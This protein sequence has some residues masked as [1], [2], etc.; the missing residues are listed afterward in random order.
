MKLKWKVVSRLTFI[1]TCFT[2]ACCAESAQAPKDLDRSEEGLKIW[3]EILELPEHSQIDQ[4]MD[5]LSNIPIDPPTE[6]GK[7]YNPSFPKD[8]PFNPADWKTN[9]PS[10]SVAN[11]DATAGGT[12][13]LA[14][15]Q[16]PPTLRTEGPNSRLAFLSDLHDLI[17]ETLLTFDFSLNDYVPRLASHWQIDKDKQTFRFRLNPKAQWADGRP[18]TSH[19]VVATIKHLKNKDRK[20]LSTSQHMEELI[21]YVKILDRQT[22]EI[23]AKKKQ[24]RSFLEI[25][26]SRVYPAAYMQMDGETYL[27][28]WN[29]RLP[30]GTGPYEIRPEDIK[31]GRSI[32][33]KKRKDWWNRDN[34]NLR[35]H[36]N[37]DRIQ[38]LIVRDEELMFQKTLA[39][40]IDAYRILRAQRWVD[41]LDQQKAVQKGWIQKRKIYTLQPNGYGGYCFNMREAPFDD[42]NIRIAFSHL[43]NREKLFE[44][45]FFFQYDYTDSYFP[46]QQWTRPEAARIA[47][48]PVKAREYLAASGWT[49]RDEQGFLINNQGDRFPK[50]EVDFSSSGFQRIHAAVKEDLWK[51]AGIEME[52]KQIDFSTTLK[53]VWEWKYQLVY[54]GWTASSFPDMEFQFHSKYAD[55]KQSNNLN[56]FKS[57]RAD[58]IME[59][60]KMEFDPTKRKTML[61]ELDQILF[62]DHPYALGWYAPYFRIIYWDKFGHPPEYSGRYGGFPNDLITYWWHDESKANKTTDN[63]SQNASNYPGNPQGQAAETEPEYWLLNEK[64][65]S[66]TKLKQKGDKR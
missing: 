19:D 27:Q 25:A 3:K 42:R 32:T 49:K 59:D 56:G 40:E 44:K 61:H 46:G 33:L 64:P 11:P 62:D 12:I 4:A 24:W 14:T 60:Y 28:D 35:G 45:F 31:K 50:L 36:Y 53:K 55:K 54:W 1:T 43:F 2:L 15:S 17:F 7:N 16:W 8:L 51:E 38:W 63:Q 10:T 30:P 52:L 21:E 26:T 13:R 18:V 37:F 58:K 9:S 65:M 34:P 41:E 57:D 20:D 6:V 23:K 5:G 66:V 29:W 39:G 47:Y 48:N 22:V